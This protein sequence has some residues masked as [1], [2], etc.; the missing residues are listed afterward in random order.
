MVLFYLRVN[1]EVWGRRGETRVRGQMQGRS[2]G[3]D[4][5]KGRGKPVLAES[6]CRGALFEPHISQR[7]FWG[8]FV[9]RICVNVA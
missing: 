5:Q 2:G 8:P 1:L 4:T 7:A 3:A 6:L 9:S